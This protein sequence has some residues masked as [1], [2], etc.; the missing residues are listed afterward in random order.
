MLV[1][2]VAAGCI[3]SGYSI[4]VANRT[5]NE[6]LARSWPMR[7]PEASA[8]SGQRVV[9]VPAGQRLEVVSIQFG[10]SPVQLVEILDPEC[11]LMAKVDPEDDAALAVINAGG[12]VNV[13][14]QNEGAAQVAAETSD[15]RV[16]EPTAGPSFAAMTTPVPTLIPTAVAAPCQPTDLRMTVARQGESGNVNV[17]VDFTNVGAKACSLPALPAGVELL[18]SDGTAL[19]LVV[20]PPLAIPGETVTL[21]PGVTADAA[22]IFYWWSWCKDPPGALRIRITFTEPKDVVITPLPGSLLPRCDTP[23]SASHLQVDGIAGGLGRP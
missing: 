6:V 12:I 4:V 11:T 22:L 8:G 13:S 16:T 14:R 18:R 17:E 23:G 19:R 9:R 7:G 5:A 3:D 10:E 2:F 21:R 20:E 15:C 1:G